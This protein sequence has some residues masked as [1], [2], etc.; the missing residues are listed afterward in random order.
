MSA[1]ERKMEDLSGKCYKLLHILGET[2]KLAIESG[3]Q[4]KR[5]GR[6]RR[7]AVR[8]SGGGRTDQQAR[9]CRYGL[10]G[11]H[12]ATFR[13]NRLDGQVVRAEEGKA[14]DQ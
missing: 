1:Y 5:S 14:L 12:H 11:E 10:G 7:G 6:L 3:K 9:R 4:C 2:K 8:K 13:G